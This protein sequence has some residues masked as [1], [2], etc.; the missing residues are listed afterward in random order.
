MI[1]NDL[2]NASSYGM[3]YVPENEKGE[4]TREEKLLQAGYKFVEHDKVDDIYQ[5]IG[6]EDTA[7]WGGI[8]ATTAVYLTKSNTGNTIGTPMGFFWQ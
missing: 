5:R 3:S 2:A 7:F 6:G 8:I 1:D 4:E